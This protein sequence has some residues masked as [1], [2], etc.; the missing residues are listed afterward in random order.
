MPSPSIERRVTRQSARWSK[1]GKQRLAEGDWIVIFP[2]GTR[3]PPGETRKYG[4]SGALLASEAGVWSC[5]SRT[6]PGVYWPRRGL[7]KKPGTIRVT[8]GPAHRGG[9]AGSLATSTRR[10]RPGLKRI[11][12]DRDGATA[13]PIGILF[14]LRSMAITASKIAVGTS[15]LPHRMPIKAGRA[16]RGGREWWRRYPRCVLPDSRDG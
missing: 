11:S 15:R 13:T 4:A 14:G 12:S 1:Q 2:E 16:D 9:G 10:R 8:I 5:P 6:M 3:M 7:L